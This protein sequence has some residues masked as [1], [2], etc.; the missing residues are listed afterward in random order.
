MRSVLAFALLLALGG[1]SSSVLIR[2]D[3]VTFDRATRRMES[4]AA[5]VEALNA[6]PTERALFLQA[7]AFYRYR[8]TP[9]PRSTF[10]YVAE[11]AAATTDFPAFQS[12]AG[13]LDLLDLRLRA[14]DA[15]VQLWETL[16]FHHPATPLRPL[17]LYRL[18]WAY[19]CTGASGLP[20]LSGDE[21]FAALVDAAPGT[22]LAALARDARRV[23]WKSKG[24]AAAWSVVPG[25]GQLYVGEKLSGA[26]RLTVA[27]S[28]LAAIAIPAYVGYRRSNLTWQR[29]WPLLATGVGGLIVLSIDYTSSYEDA[30]RGVVQF[31]EGAEAAFEDAHPDAP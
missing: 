2:A 10:S 23:P 19:R 9:P 28:A 16:L 1:C 24:S 26:V 18:G 6:T 22:P 11:I 29:D 3:D 8:F 13:S 21:A 5:R 20:R 31:N 30:M 12:L 25:L 7:E 17:A 4:T 15:A 14:N 27:L